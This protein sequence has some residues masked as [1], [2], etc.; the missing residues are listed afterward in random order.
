MKAK[1]IFLII[2]LVA[3]MFI[4]SCATSGTTTVLD[5]NIT[6]IK[7]V[8]GE[9]KRTSGGY[10]LNIKESGGKV[11]V[12]YYNPSQGYINVSQSKISTKDKEIRVEL[13]L[14]D[15]NYPDSKYDLTYV[16]DT[17]ALYGMYR[18][19]GEAMGVMF[20]RINK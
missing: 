3:I 11:E 16:K 7:P 2:S 17:D 8:M 4:Q 15:R 20:L 9:W 19:P 13:T 12:N 18:R 10:L 1:V 14:T 6:D 5:A